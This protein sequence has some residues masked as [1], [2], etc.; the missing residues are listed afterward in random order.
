MSQRTVFEGLKVLDLTHG[1]A[2]AL[3]TMIL[4]DNGAAVTHVEP[5][6]DADYRGDPNRAAAGLRQWR[7]G[8]TRLA[9]NLKS[10]EGRARA[11]ALAQEADVIV[12]AFRP[13]VTAKLGLDYET[14]ARANPRLIYCTITGFGPRGPYRDLPGYEGVVMA[15]AGRM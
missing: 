9:V 13:G 5:P 2:G 8:K 3:A 11:Q 10:D 4:A 7:R 14:L 12:S 6:E 15:L 1:F